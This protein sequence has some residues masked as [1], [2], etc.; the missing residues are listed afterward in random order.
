MGMKYTGGAINK[1]T[2]AIFSGL[3]GGYRVRYGHFITIIWGLFRAILTPIM[4]S[5]KHSLSHLFWGD[6]IESF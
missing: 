1:Q 2:G 6:I 4:V 3:I 5:K